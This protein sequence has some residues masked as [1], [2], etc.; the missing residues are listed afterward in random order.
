MNPVYLGPEWESS[1]EEENAAPVAVS[2]DDKKD[3]KSVKKKTVSKKD[4][5]DKVKDSSV[6]YVGHLPS[7]LEEN[8]LKKFL[9]QFGKLEKLRVSR[10]MKTGNPKGYAFAQFVQPSVAKIVAETLSGYF[11]GNR[12]LVCHMLPNPHEHLFFNSARALAKKEIKIKV[13]KQQRERNLTSS[14]K[15]KDITT[16]L[17]VREKKKRAKLEAMGIEYDFPGYEASVEASGDSTP[18]KTEDGAPKK[19][20]KSVDETTPS[21][22][23]DSISSETSASKKRKDS[24]GSQGSA[25]KKSKQKESVGSEASATKKG[26]EKI[27][28]PSKAATDSAT[29]KGKGKIETPNKSPKDSATKKGK[30]ETPNK[31]PKDSATKKG[32]IETPTKSPTD[33]AGK[34]GKVKV[35]TPS[36]SPKESVKGTGKME[37]RSKAPKEVAVTQSEK[38]T[39]KN[40]KNRRISAP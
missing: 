36:K 14:G 27:E 29:K 7:E 35:E 37:T 20:Q 13:A 33:S 6:I 8:D 4:V 5:I 21:K 18:K 22:R 15:M 9:G 16:K 2:S 3:A 10:S 28:T 24:V 25:S 40:T 19:K 38:K 23:K 1:D 34:K 26:L 11:L 30:I 32:K 12:R 39:K 31:S 17:I